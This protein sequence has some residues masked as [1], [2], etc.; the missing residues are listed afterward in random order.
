MYVALKRTNNMKGFCMFEKR[1][2]RAENNNYKTANGFT[3]AEVLITLGIIG[4]VAAITLPMLIQNYQRKIV[5]TRL[6]KFSSMFNQAI[7]R[8]VADNGETKY[9]DDYQVWE[10]YDTVDG[11]KVPQDMHN[12][13]DASFNKYLGKYMNIIRKKEINA[14]APYIA[15]S[16][17][18]KTYLYYLSDGSAFSFRYMHNREIIFY[19][20][21]TDKCVAMSE[22]DKIGTCAFIFSF[23]TVNNDTSQDMKYV[24]GGHLDPYMYKWD[25][26]VDNLI[27]H[28]ERGCNNHPSKELGAYFCTKLIEING[29]KIPKDYPRKVW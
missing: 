18:K 28:S 1:L 20:K 7:E 8:S 26:T 3:L 29:W 21:A 4:V 25:G 19:P 11:E 5:E 13:S 14:N 27:N 2:M 23:F 22:Y 16:A 17:G 15:G 9:W 24:R 6:A 12:E 10:K